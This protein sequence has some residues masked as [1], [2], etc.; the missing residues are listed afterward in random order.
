MAA[1]L[2]HDVG[3]TREFTYGAEIGL[4]EEGRLL[5]HLQIGAEIIGAA[6]GDLPEQRRTALLSCVLAHHGPDALRMRSFPS[7]E[8]IALYR[9]NALDAQVK[10]ALEH[11]TLRLT[12]R[13]ELARLLGIGAPRCRL[14]SPRRRFCSQPPLLGRPRSGG[15]AGGASAPAAPRPASA[16]SR[17]S[18]R[19]RLRAWLRASWAT[20][21]TRGPSFGRAAAAAAPRS[22]WSTCSTSKTASIRD[23]VTF[24]C[25]P[26]GP[27]ER[28]ARSSISASGIASSRLTTSSLGHAS[29]LR[30]EG[31]ADELDG[32]EQGEAGEAELEGALGDL[33]GDDDPDQRR[34]AARARRRQPR[35][36]G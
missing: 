23:A 11:G 14:R 9:L 36:G 21:V 33:V 2:L 32:E 27:E 13:S 5:G 20:A 10:G 4:S 24:A 31:P 8:A 35:R 34:R 15:S 25:W 1:A 19:L 22:A 18:A 12:G 17:S 29:A 28:L 30:G 16:R 7:P 26:P 3:K 6:A